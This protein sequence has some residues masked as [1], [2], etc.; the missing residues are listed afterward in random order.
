MATITEDYVSFEVAKLLKEKGFDEPCYQKYDDEGYLSFNHVG[1]VNSEKP[2]DDFY[3]LAPTLQMAM[4]WLR[5]V[6]SLHIWI[7]HAANKVLSWY[8]EIHGISDG[9]V[10]HIGGI[11]C[12]SYEVICDVAIKYCL[13]NLI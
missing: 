8:Y 5:E 4:K 9:K 12:G 1:Y 7:G 13:K 11:Q 2:C 6:H 10:K 3:A